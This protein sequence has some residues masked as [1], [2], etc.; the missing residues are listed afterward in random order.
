MTCGKGMK[1]LFYTSMEHTD[2]FPYASVVAYS[3]IVVRGIEFST[4]PEN[5]PEI[6]VCA[7]RVIFAIVLERKQAILATDGCLLNIFCFT[8]YQ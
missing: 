5:C 6:N 8:S 4:T 7:I 3:P 1:G 2:F